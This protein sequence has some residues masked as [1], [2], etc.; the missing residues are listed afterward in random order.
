MKM[1][2]DDWSNFIASDIER[3]KIMSRHA[4]KKNCKIFNSTMFQMEVKSTA[5]PYFE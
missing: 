1:I 5:A 4:T 2:S 3:S